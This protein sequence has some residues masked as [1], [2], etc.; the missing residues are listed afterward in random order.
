MGGIG[1]GT[2]VFRGHVRVGRG[3]VLAPWRGA[4]LRISCIHTVAVP[5]ILFRGLTISKRSRRI[6]LIAVAAEAVSIYAG[7][8]RPRTVGRIL[9]SSRA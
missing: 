9:N 6:V 7:Y 3:A 8:L 1:L 4:C 2:L 5:R